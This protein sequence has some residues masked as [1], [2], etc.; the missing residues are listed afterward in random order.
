MSDYTQLKQTISG[1]IATLTLNRPEKRN[2]LGS[3]LISELRSAIAALRDDSSVR[4]VLLRGAGKDFCAGADLEQLERVSKATVLEN[5]TDAERFASLILEVRQLSKPVIAAVHGRA[6]AGGAGLASACDIVI[7]SRS[8]QFGYP[9]V[10]IG[11]VAAIVLAILKRNLGE[12]RA[13]ELLA[14]GGL[15]TAEA[16]ERIGLINKVVDDG[17]FDSAVEDFARQLSELSASAIALTKS[18]LYQIDGMSFEQALRAGVEMNAIARVTPD[19]QA[20][21]KEFLSRK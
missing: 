7:A 17:E 4:V 13:F 5:R 14:T 21:L 9:E 16:V 19:C 20:G 10:K 2:A 8:A 15:W 18:L 12:K 11:F 6:L 3:V 1:P